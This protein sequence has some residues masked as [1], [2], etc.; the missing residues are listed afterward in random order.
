[1]YLYIQKKMNFIFIS[2]FIVLSGLLYVVYDAVTKYTSWGFIGI[3]IIFILIIMLMVFL[4]HFIQTHIEVSTIYKL[5]SKEKIA[6]AK[7][8]N[9]EYYKMSRD[10]FFKPHHI[11]K[12]NITVFTQDYQRIDY[13]IYEDVASDDF[14]CLPAYV[15]VTYDDK[16]Q[17][18]GIVPTFVLFMTPKLKGIVQK[19]EEK[20]E[21]HYVEVSKKDGL[22]LK[23]FK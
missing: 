2:L 22:S 9:V 19:Y 14:S 15:Y 18:M 1:M 7:I 16:H 10:I 8:N 6:L 11:Y 12:M 5:I 13:V 21:P 3:M 17:K 20:Y 4:I 23:K